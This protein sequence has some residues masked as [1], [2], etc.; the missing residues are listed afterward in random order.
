MSF[1]IV[2]MVEPDF[3]RITATGKYLAE[4]LFDFIEL[5]RSTADDAAR[6]RVFVD[7]RQIDGDMSEAERFEGGK[8]IAEVF[9]SRLKAAVVLPA[10]QVTKLG[11]LTAVN[12]G[13]K[14]LVTESESE[15]VNWLV[16]P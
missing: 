10:G 8:R 13:A 7:C 16:K 3:L 6:N 14:L 4:E 15:A 5:V 12:R 11:E 2:T 1:D 9:G